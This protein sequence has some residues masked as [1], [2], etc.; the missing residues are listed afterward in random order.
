MNY[1]TPIASGVDTRPIRDAVAYNE[2]LWHLA[3]R[4][5]HVDT[6]LVRTSTIFL[7]GPDRTGVLPTMFDQ[8]VHPFAAQAS[9]P[10]PTYFSLASYGL[11]LSVAR[12]PKR[13]FGPVFGLEPRTLASK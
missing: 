3:T 9:V 13:G 8:E 7:R 6:R 2:D 5:I 4:R 11:R 1:L 12:C 10:L